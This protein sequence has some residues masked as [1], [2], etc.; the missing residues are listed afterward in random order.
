[1]GDLLM[2]VAYNF[3]PGVDL[4][5]WQWLSFFPGGPSY[6]GTASCYDGVRYIYW[7]IQFGSTATTVSTSNLYRYDTWTN[8]W[9]Y[10]A[11]ITSGNRGMDIEFDELRN[12]LH[13]I[14]GGGLTSWQIF[15]LNVTSVT[16][17][18][19][20]CAAWALTTIATVLPV[21]ADYGASLTMTTDLD[22]PAVI[23]DGIAEVAGNT[24]STV[25]ATAATGSY[26]V[27]MV[28]L[29]LRVTSGAQVGARRTITS[30]TNKT[31]VVVAPVLGGALA[32]TDTFVIE[33][34]ASTSTAGSATTVTDTNYSWIVNQYTDHDVLITGG[35]GTGQRRRIASNTATVLTLAAAVTG[36]ARTGNFATPPDA[37]SVYRI[38]P[39]NDFLYYQPGNGNSA[40]YRIDV[41]QTTGIAFSANLGAA[42]AVI[43]PGSNTFYA[44]A[45]APGYIMALRGAATATIYMFNIGTKAWTTLPTFAGSETFTTGANACMLHGERKLFVQKEGQGRCYNFDLTTGILEPAGVLPYA[46]PGAY[47]GKRARF[48]KTPDGVEWVYLMRAGGQEFY[49]IPL[50]W[51]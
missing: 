27:G 26:G 46:S 39:S 36:N 23:D 51:V 1:M 14:N 19:T 25:V 9:Q 24:T 20:A 44:G 5:S 30:V 40:L 2:P 42:P 15:N 35:T 32:S 31:T 12:V 18:N 8:G 33:L 38:V 11:V 3:K 47:D 6:H 37:T 45:Y 21:V 48:V 43:G 17:A 34:L 22:L 7:V 13:I 41:A 28:G 49:R 29:Q 16:V 50:E 4:P 10:M